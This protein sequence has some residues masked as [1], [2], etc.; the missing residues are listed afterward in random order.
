MERNRRIRW[1]ELPP[2]EQKRLIERQ[3]EIDRARTPQIPWWDDRLPDEAS[4]NKT[5]ARRKSTR[6]RKEVTNT[7]SVPEDLPRTLSDEEIMPFV[8][9]LIDSLH[10]HQI[11]E[12]ASIGAIK[13]AFPE[14]RG[15]IPFAIKHGFV[16]PTEPSQIR[17]LRQLQESDIVSLLYMRRVFRTRGGITEEQ[18]EELGKVRS[19]YQQILEQQRIDQS[20]Q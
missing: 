16:S 14:L 10:E 6:R 19:S 1:W 13:A 17:D 15:V 8:S 4:L 11:P 2:E 3:K 12:K 18:L 7:P 20:P 5:P 9:G